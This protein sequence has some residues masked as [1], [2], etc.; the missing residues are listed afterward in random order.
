[1][2]VAATKK[3]MLGKE[4]NVKFKIKTLVLTWITT[5]TG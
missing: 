3:K 1:M 5:S 2:K 4:G